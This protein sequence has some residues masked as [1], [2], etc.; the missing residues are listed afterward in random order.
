MAAGYLAP[1]HQAISTARSG[2]CARRG[3]RASSSTAAKLDRS[4]KIAFL[5]GL[6]VLSVPA[7]YDEPKGIFLL[8]AMANG[9]PVVQPRRGAF[10]EIVEK[11]GGGLIVERGRSRRARR[12]DCWRSGAIRRA[13]PR[14]GPP[15]PRACASTTPSGAWRKTVE[16]IYHDLVAAAAPDPSRS[17]K[18][19]KF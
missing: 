15:A 16:A 11:T 13:R 17:S 1:E 5:Q 19:L 3:S 14:S 2:C 12:R 10:P 8:E 4:Q 9:V 18:V 7:T 6:D